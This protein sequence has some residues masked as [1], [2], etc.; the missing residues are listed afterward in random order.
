MDRYL[1][2]TPEF[3]DI[4]G[5][6]VQ[7]PDPDPR[8]LRASRDKAMKEGKAKGLKDTEITY[9]MP[10]IEEPSFAQAIAWFANGIPY[11]D[12]PKQGEPPLHVTPEDN[13]KA[14]HAVRAFRDETMLD[15]G[16]VKIE[17]EALKWL[18]ELIKEHAGRRFAGTLPTLIGER[19]DGAYLYQPENVPP[20]LEEA[21]AEKAAK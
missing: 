20:E 2:Y 18:R 8:K 13:A 1:K 10:M 3:V 21:K 9:E 7:I 19:L 12:P 4:M 6:P 16:Y 17:D 11:G 5:Y 15:K 14:A